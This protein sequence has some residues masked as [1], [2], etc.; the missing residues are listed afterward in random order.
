MTTTFSRA[1]PFSTVK[2]WYESVVLSRTTAARGTKTP[3]SPP[4]SMTFAVANMPG[5]S[6]P[7]G[8]SN[9]ASTM[10]M[11]DAGSIDGFTAVTLPVNTRSGHAATRALTVMPV[12][13]CA[14]RCSGVC[15]C[16]FSTPIFTIVAILL[17]SATYS[18]AATG[19][20]VM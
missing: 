20:A 7:F 4:G 1:T 2:S 8:L 18:P 15:N 14:A 12:L 3:F 16:S 10:K 19:R 17:L 11:R 5:R 9:F 13:T 6:S